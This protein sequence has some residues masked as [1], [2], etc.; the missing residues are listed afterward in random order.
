[1]ALAAIAGL[2]IVV[3]LAGFLRRVRHDPPEGAVPQSDRAALP[4]PTRRQLVAAV[5]VALV[6]AGIACAAPFLGVRVPWAERPAVTE[7]SAD[8][9][10]TA[11]RE[12]PDP[13]PPPH[14]DLAEAGIAA[15]ALGV[16]ALAGLG[17]VTVRSSRR[18]TDAAA[19]PSHHDAH[20]VV[21]RVIERGLDQVR[22]PD[23]DPRQ[24]I[25]ACYT[26]MEYAVAQAARTVF[27]ASDTAYEVLAKAVDVGA[28][29]P[30]IA[31]ELVDLF[32]EARYS[33]H[34]M[35][36]LDRATAAALLAGILDDLESRT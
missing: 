31:S 9:T 17:I 28:V 14:T 16:L 24:A 30:Q 33:E 11:V 35:T 25:I 34:P 8:P 19:D 21:R 23:Q 6:L 22:Q 32:A 36:D 5:G 20:E 12:R 15:G 2:T 7:R 26:Q 18:R 27:S 29:Q 1:M 4:R 3:A 13:V 10:G